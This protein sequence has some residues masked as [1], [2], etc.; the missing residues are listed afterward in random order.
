MEAHVCILQTAMDLCEQGFQVFVPED[1]V[2]SRRL[3]NYQNAFMRM[4]QAG[5]IVSSAESVVFEW[6]RDARHEHFK[7]IAELLR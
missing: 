5:V 2:C 3:E 6:L 4:Q 1:T 7:A